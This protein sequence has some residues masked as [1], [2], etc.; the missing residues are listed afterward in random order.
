MGGNA[1]MGIEMILTDILPIIIGVV[2]IWIVFKIISGVFRIVLSLAIISAVA[3]LF[4]G[5][6]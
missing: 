4:M 2:A 1:M 5:G 3:Y 6:L